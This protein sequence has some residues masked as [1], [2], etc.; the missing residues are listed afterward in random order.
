MTMTGHEGDKL[1][2]N[3]AH[4]LVRSVRSPKANWLTYLLSESGQRASLFLSNN[5][6]LLQ[7]AMHVQKEA[8]QRMPQ[9]QL[10]L[11]ESTLPRMQ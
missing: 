10:R 3:S 2:R 11:A 7:K 8:C 4:L 9:L 1:V 5:K 6:Q